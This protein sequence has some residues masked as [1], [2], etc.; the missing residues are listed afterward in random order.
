[1]L[2]DSVLLSLIPYFGLNSPV[3]VCVCVCMCVCVFAQLNFTNNYFSESL[4]LLLLFLN[5]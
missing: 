5:F 2:Y 4:I 1:M 3:C